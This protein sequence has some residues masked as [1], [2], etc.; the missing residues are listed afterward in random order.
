MKKYLIA[1]SSFA[2][3]LVAIANGAHEEGSETVGQQLQEFLPFEHIE[4][5]H[6]FAVIL[7][8]LLWASLAYTAYSLIQK[9][10]K[11]SPHE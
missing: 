7:S 9:F 11:T 8:I 3:P 5:G 10:R 6:W 1:I 2:L 4:H